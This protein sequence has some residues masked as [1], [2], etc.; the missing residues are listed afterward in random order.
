MMSILRCSKLGF[1]SYI[2]IFI[3]V[4]S[5][6]DYKLYGINDPNGVLNEEGYKEVAFFYIYISTFC[7]Y[8]RWQFPRYRHLKLVVNKPNF[9]HSQILRRNFISLLS[10]KQ[11]LT[12]YRRFQW[13]IARMVFAGNNPACLWL[14]LAP[15][16]RGNRCIKN[17]NIEALLKSEMSPY[18]L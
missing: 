11:T 12:L 8:C 15:S 9:G 17:R 13:S 16:H 3:N 4:S 1:I 6:C 2:I 18:I 14:T 5:V 10:Q 7:F